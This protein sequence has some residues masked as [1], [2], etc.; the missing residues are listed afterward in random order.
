MHGGCAVSAPPGVA[1]AAWRPA[2]RVFACWGC[3]DYSDRVSGPDALARLRTLLTG[4]AG[5]EVT[6]RSASLPFGEQELAGIADD[7]AADAQKAILAAVR[8]HGPGSQFTIW[9]AK[10]VIGQVSAKAAARMP[11]TAALLAAPAWDQ[12]PPRLGLQARELA[13]WEE[14]APVLRRAAETELSGQ[15]RLVFTAIELGGL[16][17]DMLAVQLSASRNAIHKALFESR[18]VLRARLAADSSYPRRSGS[19]PDGPP[20]LEKWLAAEAGDAGC[21]VTFQ[22]LDRYV[23]AHGHEPGPGQRFPGV[24]AHLRGCGACRQDCEGL[25]A[26]VG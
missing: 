3:G 8:D 13:E 5:G 1:A 4:L 10:Y 17:A 14:L 7:A 23:Q 20:W 9:A 25:L 18:R 16:P 2:A 22:V 19:I 11:H 6:R 24:A 26:A 12:P 15:Q 21:D